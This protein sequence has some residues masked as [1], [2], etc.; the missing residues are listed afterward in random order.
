MRNLRAYV[1]Q[2]KLNGKV[3]TRDDERGVVISLV[4]DNMLFVRGK[5]ELSPDSDAVA[6]ARRPDTEDGSRTIFRSKDIPAICRF[7]RRSFLPTGSCRP[8]ERV[9]CCG[10]LRSGSIYPASG[11]WR[12]DMRIRGPLAPNTSEANRARNRRVDIVL[13]KTDAQRQA[14]L[15]RQ[16]EIARIRVAKPADSAPAEAVPAGPKEAGPAPAPSPSPAPRHRKRA[17][18]PETTQGPL[19]NPN[20]RA[21]AAFTVEIVDPGRVRLLAAE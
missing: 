17:R 21:S 3:S 20:G 5:A 14:D 16:A 2:H 7:I 1:E 10:I 19:W 9:R 11:S 15:Q 6:G 4:S 12:R 8:P 18:V 13:L